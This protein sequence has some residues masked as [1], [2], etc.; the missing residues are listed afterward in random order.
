[1]TKFTAKERI[2]IQNVVANLTIMRIHDDLIMQQIKNTT[3]KT[4]TRMTL[5][6]IRQRI[7]KESAK[8]YSQLRES[9]YSY[10]HEFKERIN[11]IVDLQKRHYKIIEDNASNPGIQQT[12]LA[13]LHKL[14]VTLSNYYDI[15]PYLTATGLRQSQKD[16]EKET[17]DDR[18]QIRISPAGHYTR[19]PLVDNCQC[20]LNGVHTDTVRHIECHYCLQ[21]WCLKAIG[22]DW[23]PNPQC[24][25]GIKGNKFQPYDENYTWI[26]CSCGM[27]LKTQEI[28]EAH[29]GAYHH[30]Q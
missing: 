27:W 12:S 10:I 28:L 15:V 19:M 3:G 14:N 16:I 29:L 13:A 23:C 5:Y 1:M 20:I 30:K 8:W 17:H 6:N 2:E 25:H 9:Q 11:E 4:I 22:Q 21:I 24:S 26:E 18:G 7:K